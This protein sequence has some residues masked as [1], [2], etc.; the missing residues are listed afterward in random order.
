M[1]PKIS[2][3]CLDIFTE[4]PATGHPPLRRF[5]SPTATSLPLSTNGHRPMTSEE[6]TRHRK[7]CRGAFYRQISRQTRTTLVPPCLRASCTNSSR[8]MT[9]KELFRGTLRYFPSPTSYLRVLC[10]CKRTECVSFVLRDILLFFFFLPVAL[11]FVL[12]QR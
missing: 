6:P 12:R 8:S 2:T 9:T 10:K 1:A 5:S 3:L 4:F 11:I 7:R